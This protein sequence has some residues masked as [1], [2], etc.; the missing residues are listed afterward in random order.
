MRL[1]P[2]AL[3]AAHAPRPAPAR[4]TLPDPRS[5]DAPPTA[6][7][8]D[9]KKAPPPASFRPPQPHSS[10]AAREAGAGVDGAP[11]GRDYL[12]ELGAAQQYN[13][14]V[15]HGES[16]C[17]CGLVG[18][19]GRKKTTTRSL[20]IF[21]STGQ[22][23]DHL[24]SVFLGTDAFALGTKSDIADGSLRRTEFRE[25]GDFTVGDFYVAPAFLDAVVLHIAKNILA[26]DEDAFD[27]KVK[28][29]VI[30]GVWGGK[31]QG[32]TFQTSLAL[33]KLGA[34]AVVMSAGEM[35]D[36]WAGVPGKRVRERYRAAADLRRVRGVPTCLVINDI[37]AGCG[38]YENTQRTVNTQMVVSTLM[39]IADDPNHVPSAAD[40]RGMPKFH[41][42]VPII[43]TGNDLS[44]VFAPL[45]RDGRME[46]FYWAPTREDLTS[47]VGYMYREDDAIDVAAVHALLDAF[48][49]QSLD[50]YGALRAATYDG[51]IRTW[52][53]DVCGASVEDEE[54]NMSALSAALV[55]KEGDEKDPSTGPCLD[56]VT[57][58]LDALMAEGRRLV[59][60]Q[61]AVNSIKLSSEY[62]KNQG[63]SGGLL[64][65]QGDYVEPDE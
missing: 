60:E 24:D 10:W 32:K 12:H 6:S 9:G 61:D 25:F 43:V 37:D 42:R 57:V 21:T 40:W 65:L 56:G 2:R 8:N 27:D 31:G 49:G 38:V 45:L 63:G 62:L 19:I 15:D 64:G 47:I 39:N 7:N 53:K 4:H 46:K 44:R 51:T 13:I 30:L 35:E 28:V 55:K 50:F 5:A 48:P 41:P 54:A 20:T 18:W 16:V 58:T 59:A 29:P 11:A 23:I 34:M 22:N 3:P 52:I 36:E 1:G 14:N 26:D 33:K 17:V